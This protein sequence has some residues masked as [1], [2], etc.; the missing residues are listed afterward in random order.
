MHHT[1]VEWYHLLLCLS[2]SRSRALSPTPIALITNYFLGVDEENSKLSRIVLNFSHAFVHLIEICKFHNI[3]TPKVCGVSLKILYHRYVFLVFPSTYLCNLCTNYCPYGS[4]VNRRNAYDI[5][6]DNWC[7]GV[8][9]CP[10]ATDRR[11]TD[12]PRFPGVDANREGA[13]HTSTIP[14]SNAGSS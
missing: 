12:F 2:I 10:S 6:S 8:D 7:G 11:F 4:L 13:A 1:Y 3:T 14:Q 5:I 9:R